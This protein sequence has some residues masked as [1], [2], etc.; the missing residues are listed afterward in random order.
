MIITLVLDSCF[1]YTTKTSIW[2]ALYC[3]VLMGWSLL[4]NAPRPFWDLLCSPNL[5]IAMTWIC[6]LN[7]C[8]ETSFFQAWG[9]W[10]VRLGIPSLKSLPEDLCSGFLRPEK[11]LSTSAEFQPENLGSRGENVAPRSPRPT[12]GALLAKRVPIRLINAVKS[13]CEQLV[14]HQ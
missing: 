11:N 8:S 7:F 6:R 3:I 12:W 1:H 5:G 13:V 14:V 10:N 4:P 2:G 9:S